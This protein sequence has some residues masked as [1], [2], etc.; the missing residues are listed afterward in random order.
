MKWLT[1]K[2][3]IYIY[4]EKKGKWNHVGLLKERMII[5]IFGEQIQK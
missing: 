4:R 5:D 2:K 3:L 1:N